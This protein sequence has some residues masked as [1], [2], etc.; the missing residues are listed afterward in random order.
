[1]PDVCDKLM[2]KLNKTSE[3]HRVY[4]LVSGV[5]REVGT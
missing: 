2:N 4:T 5:Q 3:P 1:M